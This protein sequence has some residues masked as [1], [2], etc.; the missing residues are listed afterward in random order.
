LLSTQG[1]GHQMTAAN[2]QQRLEALKKRAAK[3]GHEIEPSMK[4]PGYCL[5]VSLPGVGRYMVLGR[6][7]AATLDAIAQKLDEIEAEARPK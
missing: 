5:W 3:F 6:E 1:D 2:E 7:G 4:K